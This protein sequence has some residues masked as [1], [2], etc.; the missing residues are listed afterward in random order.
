MN[1]FIKKILQVKELLFSA[2]VIIITLLNLW[3]TIKL[4]PLTQ[5]IAILQNQ[6]LAN[7]SSIN[8]INIAAEKIK[9]DIVIEVRANRE[10]IDN[11][12]RLLLELK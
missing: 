11:I 9:N 3:I 8:S 5:N 7:E 1:G 2:V 10:R 12:Y 6:V 4:I